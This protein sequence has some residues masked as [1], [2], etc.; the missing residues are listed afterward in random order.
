MTTSSSSRTRRIR[1]RTGT[2]RSA[3]TVIAVLVTVFVG[4][5]AYGA[6]A[7]VGRP[8]DPVAARA[9]RVAPP[10]PAVVIGDSAIAALR[11]VPNAENAIVGFEHT[12]D[13]E[14]CRRLYYSSCRGREGRT[15]KSV[16]AALLDHSDNY[17]TLV[18]AAGYNDGTSGFETSFRNIVAR[19]R[20]L[21]YSRIVWYTLRSDVDYVSPGS[22]GNH[23]TFA[24]NN[25]E[26]RRL[27]DTGDFPDV[28]IADWGGYTADRQ[29]WFATDGVHYRSLGAWAAADYLTRKMAFLDGRACPVPTTPNEPTENPCPDPDVT[30]P[31]ADIDGLYTVG[32]DGL[33]CY[34]IGDER[35]F[36]CRSDTHVLQLTR[37]L[38]PGTSGSDVGALQTRLQ[39]LDLYAGPI[40][41]LYGPTTA[42]AV[43]EFQDQGELSVTGVA[44]AATLDAL[45]FD[46]SAL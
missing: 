17:H 7:G 34:E 15:P 37:E 35:R 33:L 40:D 39:R 19:A 20:D 3:G 13:L 25:A 4:V 23:E 9:V 42:A 12:L 6:A 24:A 2:I 36:E 38:G 31:V 8:A 28:V 26:L 30:G 11:W 43:R 41:R 46:T 29:E 44:D 5:T 27:I 32:E 21:G 14:S 10:E 16:H 18:V 22:V 1:P 45:G